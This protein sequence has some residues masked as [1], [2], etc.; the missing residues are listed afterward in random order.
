[1]LRK[2]YHSYRPTPSL[3]TYAVWRIVIGVSLVPAFGTL[4]QRLTLP[5]STRYTEAQRVANE[6][7]LELKLKDGP[8]CVEVKSVEPAHNKAQFAGG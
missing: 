2:A 5:E 7:D 8:S 6:S 4:Y 3:C 1:M